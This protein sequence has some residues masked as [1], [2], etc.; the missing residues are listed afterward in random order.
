MDFKE[1][2]YADHTAVCQIGCFNCRK[3]DGL[4]LTKFKVGV[5]HLALLEMKQL[6]LREVNRL[7]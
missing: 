2:R 4:R 3:M 5:P 7:V 1:H 6:R